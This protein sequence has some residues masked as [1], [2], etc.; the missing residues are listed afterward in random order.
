MAAINFNP[1]DIG[2]NFVRWRKEL[3]STPA[4]KF[5]DAFGGL[6]KIRTGIRYQ[7]K[8]GHLDGDMQLGPY[9]P[10]RIDEE[11]AKITARTLQVYLGSV[12]KQIDPNSAIQSIWD[13]YVAKGDSVKNIPFV[14]FVAAFFMQKLSE[15]LYN[16]VWDGVRND[17]GT[18]TVDLCDGIE[19]I[20]KKEIKAGS[21]S[22]DNGNLYAI[23]AITSAN[24]EDVFKDFY[25]HADKHLRSHAK[26][27]LCCSHD[28][29]LKYCDAYQSNHG[30]LPYNQKYD[31]P[32]L[33]GS[34]GRCEIKVLDGVADNFL[35]LVPA[36]NFM[37][38]TN[39]DGEETKMEICK[40]NKSH[41]LADLVVTMF[42]GYQIERIEKDSMLIGMPTESITSIKNS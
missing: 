36:G 2:Q 11:A 38:G 5:R 34:L 26:H 8:V 1:S 29:Y 30:A 24:A 13:E 41:F 37:F 25:R 23:E 39:I 22:T 17:S 20:I 27:Y 31:Q 18:K 33:E 19:T 7:E 10:F 4:F 14:K 9:D 6:F 28:E 12:V 15:N 3:L 32:I 40:S 35:K 16:H 42:A 21:V